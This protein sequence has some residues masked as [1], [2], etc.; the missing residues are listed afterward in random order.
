MAGAHRGDGPRSPRADEPEEELDERAASGGA[1]RSPARL[2]RRRFLRVGLGG[3]LGLGLAACS[4]GS[5][6][7][8]DA[9]A[10]AS[11][12]D[13]AAPDAGDGARQPPVDP[14]RDGGE[15]VAWRPDDV[16]PDEETFELGIQA[17]AATASAALLW[18]YA[19]DGAA[20]R[21]R[22]WRDAGGDGEV[23]L[24]VDRE[25]SPAEGYVRE[26]VEGLA[27]ATSYRYA[28]FGGEGETLSG[29]SA[30]GRFRT[31]H[32]AGWTAAV[33]LAGTACT[34]EE[35]KPFEALEV[36]A[37]HDFDGFV[38]LGDFSYNDGARTLEEFRADWRRT[39]RDPGYHALLP[40]AAL[41]ATLDDHEITNNDVRYDEISDETYQTGL[42]AW[43][44]HVAVPR[45]EG[46]R[47]WDSYRWGDTLELF[48]LDAR[49]ERQ[50]ETRETDEA[51]F[52]SRAQMDWLKAGLRDSPCH[53]KAV[54]TSVP[55][56]AFPEDF[57]TP[58][59]ESDRWQGYAA[60]RDELLD[61]LV[62]EGIRNVWF[63]TGDFHMGMVARV[64]PEGP[65]HR[66]REIMMG[67][68][69][70]TFT[71]L[72]VGLAEQEEVEAST[73][74]PPEQFEW[75]SNVRAATLVTFDPAADE[76]RVRFLRADDGTTLM[77][78]SFREPESG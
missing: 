66:L 1:P 60:Q 74:F 76:V 37:E 36:T 62:D 6:R 10:D 34:H 23:A 27:P 49:T 59:P 70:P 48:V 28:F 41:Y 13:G 25:V 20:K 50:P 5:G 57:P 33:T 39:L 64:E 15:I 73:L 44:E 40:Q 21:L 63:L 16:A 69:D 67:P 24:V 61:H 19:A 4:E 9:M 18:T 3:T 31:L 56:T 75:Y 42:D 77:E 72:A 35:Q 51:I 65:R 7:P 14:S 30:I 17:G 46:D 38:H 71:H 47:F 45:R 11:G 2:D 43:F 53:F 8:G 54:A 22:V 32:P 55:I 26:A 52:L 29:R 68:G 12:P 58:P 78:E